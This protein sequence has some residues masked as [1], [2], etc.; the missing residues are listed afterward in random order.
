MTDLAIET[1]ALD[2]LTA[3]EN[4]A[5][6]HDEAQIKQLMDS[7]TEFGFTNP[8][9]IDEDDGIIAGHGRMAAAREL[10]L[11]EVP[12]IVL[13]GLSEA[14]RRAY[15]IADNKLA[16]NAT[17]D[18]ALLALELSDLQAMDFDLKLTG[19]EPTEIDALF[20]DD[21]DDENFARNI[22]SP[23]YK[24]TGE[25]PPVSALA[26]ATRTAALKRRIK[27]SSAPPQLKSFLNRA[28]ERHTVF[29]FAAIAE[30][31]SHADAEVQSLMEQSGLVIV[32]WGRAIEEGFV[33]L[34]K[35]MSNLRRQEDDNAE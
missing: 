9:L 6:L 30:F 23:I 22:E 15:I 10:G 3:F 28:A 17:W 16:L 1:R 19:F 2:A 14:Q 31:Y 8:L 24:P 33:R 18:E 26:D 35:A 7:I 13:R 27:E 21:G 11:T 29:N 4:N 32:D 34:T 25:C 5:R 12:C 20:N